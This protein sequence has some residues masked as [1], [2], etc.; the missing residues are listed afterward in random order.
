MDVEICQQLKV[1]NEHAFRLIYDRYYVLLCRFANQLLHNPVV[2]EEIVDDVIFNL[3]LHRN[4]IDITTSL[5]AYLLRSVRNRCLNELKDSARRE[6]ISLSSLSDE[7]N[8]AFLEYLFAD[9]R[10]PLGELIERELE[11]ELHR[12]IEELPKE[13]RTCFKKS[14]IEHKKYEE[15]ASELGVSVNTVKYH[16]KNA[17]SILQKRFGQY[18]EVLL[19]YFFN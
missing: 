14:R 7:E 8:I 2:T 10:H 6:E 12:A 4:D 11:A 18:I 5:R 17:L 13:C 16:M 19:L 15:I 1:G 3:W 9:E